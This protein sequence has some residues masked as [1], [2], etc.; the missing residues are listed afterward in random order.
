LAHRTLKSNW[1]AACAAA[2]TLALAVAAAGCGGAASEVDKADLVNGKKL[3]VGDGTCG[4]CHT[5]QRA[6]TKGTQGPNLDEAFQNA[7][8]NGFGNSV[9]E[10]VVRGQIAHP[11]R[12]SIMQ[13]DLVTGDDARDVAAYVGE[14]AGN[15]GKD[16]GLLASVGV[17]DT[18]NQVTQAK[19]GKLT[20][21]AA[22]AGLAF[23]YGKATAPAGK[24][25]IAMPNPQSVQHDIALK[26]PGKGKG[27][28][29]GKGGTSSF[30]TTLKPG[31]YEY[32]CSV[33]GHEEGGMK[34][35]LTVK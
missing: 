20:I 8:K 7:R 5:L 18:S 28:E 19:G 21:P 3:F 34:G 35:T 25:T 16:G 13:P 27:P 26:P 14:A 31:T 29:V 17:Q 30:T 32:Y 24:L 33:P 1:R 12:G 2:V 10:G 4:A 23:A 6:G 15:P 9:I 22:D 11:R